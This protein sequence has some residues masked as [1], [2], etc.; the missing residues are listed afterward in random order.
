[1]RKIIIFEGSPRKNGNSS[2]LARQVAAGAKQ[3]GAEVESFYLHGMDIRPC[4]ACDACQ[5]SLATDCIIE[6]DL[7]SLYPRLRS[8]DALVFASPVYWFSFSAQLKLLIDRCY[9]LTWIET[10]SPLTEEE[11]SYTFTT[12]L[13]GKKTGIILTYGDTDPFS[14]GAV[15]ALRTFQDMFRFVG[16]DIVDMIYGSAM[17]PGEV[18]E[19]HG[20]MQQAF[21]LGKRLAETA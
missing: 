4:S 14:S 7:Q 8:A 18:A 21:T 1:M 6:D 10:G 15:N 19:N 2:L 17:A 11:T 13:A 3:H 9:A 20:L 12:D 16:A 5:A